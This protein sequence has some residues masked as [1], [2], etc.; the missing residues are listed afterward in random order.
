MARLRQALDSDTIRAWL[1]ANRPGNRFWFGRYIGPTPISGLPTA[2]GAETN[3][4][5]ELRRLADTANAVRGRVDAERFF[6]RL[7][8]GEMWSRWD[9][10][11]APPD[12]LV[13]NYSMLNIMLMR[14]IEASIFDL[15]R[16]WLDADAS[17]I[18]HL[19]VD[20]LHAYRGTP[21]TE[22]AYILRVLLDRLGL[23]PDHPQLRIIASSASLGTDEVRAQE[24]LGQFF[25]SSRQFDLVRGGSIPIP[26]GARDRTR[27]LA[28]PFASLGQA[29]E[30]AMPAEVNAAVDAL[31]T[32]AG[33]VRPS[34]D[35]AIERRIGETLGAIS[36]ADTVRAA[37]NSGTDADPVVQPLTPSSIGRVLF[38]DSSP[39]EAVSA[40]R[41]VVASIASGTNGQN[42]PLLPLRMHV[43][44]R[45]VQGVWACSNPACT[46][47]GRTEND[48]LVGRLFD[49][50]TTTCPCGSRVLELLYCEPCGDVFLGGHRREI[51]PN[52]WSLVPDDPN[53]EKAPDHSASDREYANF[54]VYWPARTARGLLDPPRDRWTQDNVPRQW[55]MATYNSQTGE[56]ELARSRQQ[57]T[58]WIYYVPVLHRMPVPAAAFTASATNDRP[59]LC[60]RCEA[61]WSRMAG[62]AP[63]RTQRTGF[64]KTAQ[65]LTDA[66]LREIAPIPADQQPSEDPRRKL[67]LFSDSRQ[68]AAKLAVGVAKSHWLDAMRQ[69]LVEGITE[70]AR[71]ILA[72]VRQVRREALSP[73]DEELAN[74]FAASRPDAAGAIM[75]VQLGEAPGPRRWAAS[76]NSSWRIRSSLRHKMVCFPSIRWRIK[77]N[78][79][80]LRPA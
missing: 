55:R 20:E 22:V 80:F 30:T 7:N 71:A 52:V 50:P 13:T 56:I 58:G 77:L 37:C 5:K 44:F 4:R 75:A 10:Q 33:I 69:V 32:Q 66:L 6:P 59:A 63:I 76:R 67:V 65:V 27:N 18:F 47:V 14:D 42:A 21:G 45:N 40:G 16:A 39:D 31:S 17:H 24:Y 1:S 23:H 11:E 49:R 35:L 51:R 73:Q 72:F 62:G 2:D 78:E 29:I 12:V 48:I 36:L 64:Q 3:L 15:T 25:G 43:F 8:G 26:A 68:D 46:E 57:A 74:R 41:G 79:D 9:M 28:A 38:P 53:I 34:P 54:A 70:E 60:P 19:V 61:N